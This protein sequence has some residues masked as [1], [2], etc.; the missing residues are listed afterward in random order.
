MD[1]KCY[2]AFAG[3]NVYLD[4]LHHISWSKNVWIKLDMT[5]AGGQ[6]HNGLLYTHLIHECTLYHMHTGR[7]SHAINLG[8]ETGSFVKD[9]K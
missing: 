2:T 9:E 5:P 3:K 7:T 1:L 6:C 4:N 8:S